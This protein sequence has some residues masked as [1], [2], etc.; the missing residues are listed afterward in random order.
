MAVPVQP[1]LLSGEVDMYPAPLKK[2]AQC[3]PV[4]MVT[5]RLS[6]FAAVPL[7]FGIRFPVGPTEAVKSSKE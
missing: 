3:S 5:P 4:V 7:P 1:T 6:T 2:E